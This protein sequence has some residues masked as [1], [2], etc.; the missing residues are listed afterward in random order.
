VRSYEHLLEHAE[1]RRHIVQFYGTN[2]RLL[3]RNLSLYLGSG[4]HRGDHALCISAAARRETL[5][6]QLEALRVDAGA[7]LAAK[8]LVMLN[9]EETLSAILVNGEPDWQRF[10]DTVEP[11]VR[12]LQPA[13]G[14]RQLRVYGELVDLLW[15][16]GRVDAAIRLEAMWNRFFDT[17]PLVCGYGVDDPAA[18]HAAAVEQ[19]LC[20]HTH[21]IGVVH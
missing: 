15:R 21:H 20:A 4:L 14:H 1:P 19:L 11:V 9:A 16:S 2:E 13:Q 8:Q 12:E 17:C 7:A 3:I 5:L 6:R 18:G 10:A